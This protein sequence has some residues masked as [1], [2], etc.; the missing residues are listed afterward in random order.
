MIVLPRPTSSAMSIWQGQDSMSR[1][2]VRTW[3]GQGV[4]VDVTSPTR[5]TVPG[6]GCVPDVGPDHPA[7]FVGEQPMRGGTSGGAGCRV[8]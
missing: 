5:D 3:W 8:P 1:W 2:Y 6:P 4:T 7:G